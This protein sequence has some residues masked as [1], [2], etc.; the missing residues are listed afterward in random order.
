MIKTVEVAS[1]RLVGFNI[2]R[3]FSGPQNYHER[4]ILESK[5]IASARNILLEALKLSVNLVKPILQIRS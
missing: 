5:F 1:S 2:K 3:P 4:V